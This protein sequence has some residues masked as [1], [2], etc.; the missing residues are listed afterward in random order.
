MFQCNIRRAK[1]P[2]GGIIGLKWPNPRKE[3][4]K[5][6]SKIE[7]KFEFLISLLEIDI[8]R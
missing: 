7:K 2:S 4:K 8:E 1:I 3:M 5:T 6:N